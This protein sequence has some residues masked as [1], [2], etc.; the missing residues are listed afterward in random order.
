MRLYY[1]IDSITDNCFNK[2]PF[3]KQEDDKVPMVGSVYC[4]HKCKYCYGYNKREV[5]FVG[6]PDDNNK[7]SFHYSN[8]VK[9]YYPYNKKFKY[10]I[11]KLFKKL[12]NIIKTY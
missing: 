6:Y 5:G 4:K 2:C 10:R 12:F 9:C 11:I 1:K 8:Y 7:I 3:L